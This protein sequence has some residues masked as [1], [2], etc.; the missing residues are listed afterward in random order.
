MDNK[1]NIKTNSEEMENF[2][3]DAM[4]EEPRMTEKDIDDY[5]ELLGEG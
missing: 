2:A 5:A 1:N 4:R 3:L